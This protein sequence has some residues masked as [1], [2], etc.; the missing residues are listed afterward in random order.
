MEYSN[1]MDLI[2]QILEKKRKEKEEQE[3]DKQVEDVVGATIKETSTNA[4]SIIE[5]PTMSLEDR[6]EA[7]EMLKASSRP[8]MERLMKKDALDKMAEE[9]RQKKL[10]RAEMLMKKYGKDSE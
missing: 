1:D 5:D 10:K 7:S 6:I 4:P 9:L 8:E 2:K 3:L